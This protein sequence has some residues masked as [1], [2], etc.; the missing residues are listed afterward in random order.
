MISKEESIPV[1]NDSYLLGE[2]IFYYQFNDVSFY[3]EDDEQE[4]FFFSILKKL[5]PDIRLEKIFPL[6]GKENVVEE[7]R[8]NQENKKKIFI[9]DKDFDD[10]LGKIIEYSNLFYLDRYSIENYL[11]EEEALIEYV[12]SERPRLKRENIHSLFNIEQCLTDIFHALKEIVYLHVL[13]Q[14]KCSSLRNI[15]LNHERFIQFHN[16][17]FQLNDG[18]VNQYKQDIEQELKN[19][20]GRLTLLGQLQKVKKMLPLNTNEQCTIHIPGKYTVKMLK[21]MIESL[22]GL[23]SR[24][25]DSFSFHVADKSKF[26]SLS[27]LKQN[28]ESYM[29]Q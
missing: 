23:T 29:S 15:S 7:A 1:K 20:D 3:V 22:F 9:V 13:V 11:L 6:G 10:V 21:R 5:F 8:K 16:S 17:S 24:N 14:L 26:D 27:N 4:N 25:I 28:I 18:N 2:D 19:I 12:I